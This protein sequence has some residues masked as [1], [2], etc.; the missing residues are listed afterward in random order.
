MQRGRAAL[1]WMYC[2][3]LPG[4]AREI[5]ARFLLHDPIKMLSI[6]TSLS[7]FGY[8]EWFQTVFHGAW[9]SL[10]AL[11]GWPA[12]VSGKP[13]NRNSGPP[14]PTSTRT[15]RLYCLNPGT[16]HESPLTT[17]GTHAKSLS[18]KVGKESALS[19][20]ESS[21]I[22]AFEPCCLFPSGCPL[23]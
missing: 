11:S 8:V 15:A 22:S 12:W 13:N 5:L 9:N 16:F 21:W 17:D 20:N 2:L 6:P 1:G 4:V 19:L 23:N 14:D 18:G 10:K 7:P 3:Q